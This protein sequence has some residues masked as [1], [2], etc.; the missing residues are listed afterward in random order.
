MAGKTLTCPQCRESFPDDSN[1][2]PACGFAA[3][4]KCPECGSRISFSDRFCSACGHR[5]HLFCSSCGKPVLPTDRFCIHCGSG[6][7]ACTLPPETDTSRETEAEQSQEDADLL[8]PAE[9]TIQRKQN[10]EKPAAGK[11]RIP[12]SGEKEANLFPDLSFRWPFRQSQK[13]ILNMVEEKR[14]RGEKKFHIVAPPGSG[15]TIVGLE[16]ARRINRRTLILTPNTTIQAQWAD[17]I[18]FFLKE[19]QD[20]LKYTAMSVPDEEAH[21]AAITILTYQALS[22]QTTDSDFLSGFALK[23]WETTLIRERE[24]EAE[25]AK[26]RITALQEQNPETWKKELARYKKAA[27]K[28]LL[29]EDNGEAI[30]RLLHSSIPELL[31]RFRDNN[32]QTLILDECHHLLNYWA[33]VLKM[34]ICLLGDITVIG[35][36]ATPPVQASDQELRLYNE[37][38]GEI[39]FS[40]PLPAVVKEGNLATYSDLVY[41]TEPLEAE[42]NFIREQNQN[43]NTVFSKL[44]NPEATEHTLIQWMIRKMDDMPQKKLN[45]F[46]RKQRPLAQACVKLLKENNVPEW[47]KLPYLNTGGKALTLE[48]K[49][50]LLEDYALNCL[51][52]S[53][54]P[55]DAELLASLKSAMKNLGYLLAESGL[56]RYISPVDRILGLSGSKIRALKTILEAEQQSMNGQLRAVVIC[57]YEKTSATALKQLSGIMDSEAGGAVRALRF[58]TSDS[59][60]DTLDPVLVTGTTILCDDDLTGNFLRE[61]EKWILENGKK[62]ILKAEPATDGFS[63][64]SGSGRDFS[65]KSYVLMI[66][67]LFDRGITRCLV[68]TRGLLG[69]GWDSTG[70]NTLIDLTA[71][72]SFVSINQ[73]RGRS[74]RIDRNHPEKHANNWDVVCIAPDYS[75][76]LNDYGRFVRKHKNLYGLCDDGQIENGVAHIS[77]LFNDL[78]ATDIKNSMEKINAEMMGRLR[79]RAEYRKLWKVDKPYQGKELLTVELNSPEVEK[80]GIIPAREYLSGICKAIYYTQKELK[81]ISADISSWDISLSEREDGTWRIFLKSVVQEE[82]ALFARSIYEMFQ[83]LYAARY[84]IPRLTRE[85]SIFQMLVKNILGI[86]YNEN[87]VYHPVP[88]VFGKNKKMIKKFTANWHRYVTDEME[89]LFIKHSDRIMEIEEKDEQLKQRYRP[90]LKKIWV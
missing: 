63:V 70:C 14:R 9:R 52:L 26:E 56:R 81:F 7:P 40:I 87:I 18:R 68:G 31:A 51:K 13:T 90:V 88:G 49:S 22:I 72:T 69:E 58:L 17:K 16:L 85:R 30:L 46:F 32:V 23:N 80:K 11:Q 38:V 50:L 62:I 35:L 55:H 48:E 79:Q 36:T 28:K 84:V 27:R 75:N 8:Q 89:P 60:L 54:S 83:P 34:A 43:F 20:A 67:N 5:L 1:V 25:E 12:A 76:G 59:T 2:C 29:E 10:S 65:P 53:P 21:P 64:I 82:S 73:L 37:I 86:R 45:A 61:S 24:M 77:P 71:V 15:K 47:K 39:D 57:D 33:A 19:E 66:T 74:I 42:H 41:L 78:E 3:V 6:N 4:S 44:L